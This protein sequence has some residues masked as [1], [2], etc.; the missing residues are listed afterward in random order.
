MKRGLRALLEAE[1]KKTRELYSDLTR[2]YPADREALQRSRTTAFNTAFR[3]ESERCHL[4]LARLRGT[5]RQPRSQQP[6]EP[7]PSPTSGHRITDKTGQLSEVERTLL[8]KGPKFAL[9]AGIDGDTME[10]C[11]T[12]FARF[13]YQ[14]RWAVARNSQPEEHP[15]SRSNEGLPV[16]PRSTGVS[17][18]P[19]DNDTDA[20]LRRVYYAVASVVENLP[21][22][23]RWS[24]LPRKEGEALQALR[25]K[26]IALMPSDK[27]GEFCAIDRDSYT[28]LGRSHLSDEA[29]YQQ[30]PRMTAKTIEG[31]INREWRTICRERGVPWRCERSFV[32]N[33]THLATFR[34]LVKTHKP[35]PQLKIR[36]IV[37]GIGSPTE[38]ISWL[39]TTLLSPLLNTV[40]AH[41]PDSGHLMT[42]LTGAAP[43]VLQRH[44]YQVSLDV[45]SL[46]TS[47]P[48]EDALSVVRDK[49]QREEAATPD[50]LQT[51][52]VVALLRT[53]FNLTYFTYEGRIYKQKAGLPMGCAVSGIVAILFLE[54]IE[55]RALAQF[56]RCPLFLRYVDDCYALVKNGEE[57]RELHTLFNSQHPSIKFELETCKQEGRTT[58]LSLLDLTVRV[59]EGGRASFDFYT[60]DAKSK[61]FLHKESALPW[62]QKAAAIRNEVRRIEARSDRANVNFNRAAF[63]EKLRS[64]GYNDRDLEE[65]LSRRRKPKRTSQGPVYY[66]NLPFLGESAEHKIRRAFAREGIFVRIVRRS[67]TILDIVR[68]KQP[69]VRRCKWDP[70]PTKEAGKCFIKDCVYE[71]TC[72]PCGRRYVGSTTR[73]L[74][75]RIREHTSSGRGSTIH[76][77]LILCGSGIAQVRVKVVAREKDEVNAR[78]REAIVIKKTQPD[79]NTQEDNDLIDLVF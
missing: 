6:E 55:Q 25:E 71:I 56:A 40:P 31:K 44:P 63:K 69:E 12:S 54:G 59:N 65:T 30:V 15:A 74:H 42:L 16:F 7:V 3:H 41:M 34:H 33:N 53:I 39:L 61:I 70:C 79:L 13:A 62:N 27:G 18:P 9:A 5:S 36:P 57:A 23:R 32:S 21:R 64:N 4:K 35:G 58:S 51:E 52:D 66:I 72:L 38:K 67:T 2:L 10:V 8:S 19:T 28:E 45:V 75:E 50:P 29:T 1:R 47:V 43:Q 24:N 17:A 77:H 60:K 26:P 78:I 20:K 73:A 37:A 14:F 48:V 76:D 22:R 68:P 11:Q 49:L 46:Y